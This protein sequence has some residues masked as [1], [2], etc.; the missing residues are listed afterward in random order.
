MSVVSNSSGK[1]SSACDLKLQDASTLM[2]CSLPIIHKRALG[3]SKSKD[4]QQICYTIF[5]THDNYGFK[6]L[7][8]HLPK[9]LIKV[10]EKHANCQIIVEQQ[11]Y[12]YRGNMVCPIKI[13]GNSREDVLKCRLTL[14]M[15]LQNFFITNRATAED[16]HESIK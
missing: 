13:V 16:E 3:Y 7:N 5:V 8:Q 4:D 2:Q 14:P 15:A 12:I 1:N 10:L 11:K 9:R 6:H